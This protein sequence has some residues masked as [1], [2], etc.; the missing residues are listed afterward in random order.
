MFV[1]VANEKYKGK[2]ERCSIKV[3]FFKGKL[4]GFLSALGCLE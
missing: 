3:F 2:A 1:S 4:G